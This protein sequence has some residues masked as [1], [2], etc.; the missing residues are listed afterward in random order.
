[1]PD[2][3]ALAQVWSSI[4][5]D[6]FNGDTMCGIPENFFEA[7]MKIGHPLGIFFNLNFNLREK[8]Y[9]KLTTNRWNFKLILIVVT[10]EFFFAVRKN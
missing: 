6:G 10:V 3:Q 8:M 5:A 1:M 4:D 9:T 7:S 2:D